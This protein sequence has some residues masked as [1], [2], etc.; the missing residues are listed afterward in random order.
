MRPLTSKDRPCPSRKRRG[1]KASKGSHGRLRRPGALVHR[2]LA[3]IYWKSGNARRA[4][5]HA[6]RAQQFGVQL[7][8]N[9]LLQLRNAMGQQE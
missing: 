5:E 1:A 7:A 4:R 6:Q 9:F 8:P 2:E 3:I